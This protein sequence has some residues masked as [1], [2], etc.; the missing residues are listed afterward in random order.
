MSPRER[1]LRSAVNRLLSQHGVVHGTLVRRQRTCGKPNCR[2]TR[3][4]LHESLYLVVTEG[5][6]SRQMYVPAEWEALV[7]EWIDNYNKT[8]ELMDDLSA[9]HWEK[10]KTRQR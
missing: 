2:C 10:I 3:G 5:S 1:E 9:V 8:R 4:H 6:Q 7:R